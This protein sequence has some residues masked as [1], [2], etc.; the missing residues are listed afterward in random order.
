MNS[1]LY[2]PLLIGLSAIAIAALGTYSWC[3]TVGG[4]TLGR[5]QGKIT[6]NNTATEQP[7]EG[8]IVTYYIHNGNFFLVNSGEPSTATTDDAGSA[9][10]SFDRAFYS[11]LYISLF[12][13][14]NR[15]VSESHIYPEDIKVGTTISRTIS[16]RYVSGGAEGDLIELELKIDSWSLF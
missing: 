4:C 8:G 13:E 10:I 2:K 12:Q 11:S 3:S 9:L 5:Y 16:E 14:S 1:K 7:V 15:T 6:F